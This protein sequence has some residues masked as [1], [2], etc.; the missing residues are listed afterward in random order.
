LAV[1]G[2]AAWKMEA[3]LTRFL[4]RYQL[5]NVSA[6]RLLQGLSETELN[7]PGHAVYSIDW[8]YPTAGETRTALGSVT[9]APTT[10]LQ[11]QREHAERA[12]REQL[13]DRS[14]LQSVF[15]ATLTTA[16]HYAVIR[17]Q[18]SRELTLGWPLL[19][20]SVHRIGQALTRSGVLD[21]PSEVFFLTRAEIEQTQP[22]AAAA[23][24]RRTEW[25]KQRRLAAPLA[26]GTAPPLIGRHLAHV[27]G[28][29]RTSH[30]DNVLAGQPASSGRATGPARIIHSVADFHKVQPGDVL[31]ARATA[32]AW[33]PLFSR[34]AAVVT[35]GGTLAAHASL[36]AREYGIPAVVATATATTRL[37]DGQTVTVDGALGTVNITPVS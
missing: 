1:V 10:T 35:D 22:L 24:Q 27:L 14:R 15:S 3:G 30:T 25:E 12:C 28:L 23:R 13:A 7:T 16:Q 11:R 2:G 36:I 31:V 34:V 8:Y 37:H 32:P 33:T 6:Q 29:D 21:E 5:R 19:R 9:S 26:I 4:N 20:E 17:E 18:Q